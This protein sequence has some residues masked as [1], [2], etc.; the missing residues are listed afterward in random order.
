MS[1]R[2]PLFSRQQLN[3]III[4][5]TIVIALLSL[6][7]PSVSWPT[8]QRQ[9]LAEVPLLSPAEPAE[10]P[11]L[12]RLVLL[13]PPYLDADAPLAASLE[14]LL[15]TQLSAQPLPG[16]IQRHRLP[17]RLRLT[18]RLQPDN[19]IDALLDALARRPDPAT[20][21][22][23]Q[24]RLTA[25]RRLA[26]HQPLPGAWPDHPANE[27]SLEQ[28]YGNWISRAQLRLIAAR[29]LTEQERNHWQQGL[30]RLAIGTPWPSTPPRLPASTQR[31]A[32]QTEH[33]LQV[34]RDLPG[35][36][37][38]DYD[39]TL[40]AVQWLQQHAARAGVT[41]DWQ[42]RRE[43]SR[44]TLSYRGDTAIEPDRLLQQLAQVAR[45]NDSDVAAMTDK[46]QQRLHA[47][48]SQP[49]G[50]LDL[51]ETIATYEL[52]LDA[53]PRFAATIERFDDASLQRQLGELLNPAA[54]QTYR[55]SPLSQEP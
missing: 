49:L 10:H 32:P 52:P 44:L 3:W 5:L 48:L 12:L 2:K 37:A 24:R 41:L 15:A 31:S 40:L 46:L 20:L 39:P 7:S 43:R 11:D 21:A 54:Y 14:Q 27:D 23:A 55:L 45:S 47:S 34:Q 18:L 50:Y 1:S 16:L 9:T 8:L 51:L 29:P 33:L 38:P 30:Q 26:D 19:A 13:L 25:A 17:D 36:H 22:E 4:I 28:L 6:S 42:P 53:L 35:R